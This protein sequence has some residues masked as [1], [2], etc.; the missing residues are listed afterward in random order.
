MT[1]A[2]RIAMAQLLAAVLRP[3]RYGWTPAAPAIRCIRQADGGV[4]LHVLVQEGAQ[5]E[6]QA[7]LEREQVANGRRR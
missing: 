3:W 5:D 7:L 1:C 2:R 4:A 6:V